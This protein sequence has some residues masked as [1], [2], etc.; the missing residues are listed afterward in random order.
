MDKTTSNE[1]YGTAKRWVFVVKALNQPGTL[2][3]AASVFSNRGV[4]LEGILGSGIHAETVED[5]RMLFCFW[6]TVEKKEL[7]LRS[8]QRLPSIAH[9][10]DYLY[11]DNRIR[12]IAI[13]KL[14]PPGDGEAGAPPSQPDIHLPDLGQTL[15]VETIEKGA[16]F[17][18]LLISG[19]PEVVKSVIQ[20]FRKQQQLSD[21]VMSVITV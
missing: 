16:D 6:A 19:A 4:S 13:V 1:A 14:A 5:G 2:T 17:T 11:E 3:A 21:V 12:A 20:A 10:A 15:H 9:V 18:L 7:L 8:L